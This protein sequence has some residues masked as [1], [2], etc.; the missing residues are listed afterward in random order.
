MDWTFFI[1]SLFYG[2]A[3]NICTTKNPIA[4]YNKLHTTTNYKSCQSLNGLH[5]QYNFI[6][7]PFVKQMPLW[8]VPYNYDLT[9]PTT[10]YNPLCE[11]LTKNHWR[12]CESTLNIYWIHGFFFLIIYLFRYLYA[13]TYLPTYNASQST[14]TKHIIGGI[15]GSKL[16]VD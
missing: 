9:I 16:N 14:S 7:W 1:F 2:H 5:D 13:C 11:L 15:C 6:C 3:C 4:T 8:C 10:T 12:K